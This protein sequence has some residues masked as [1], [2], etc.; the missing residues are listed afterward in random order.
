[1]FRR[2]AQKRE[3][4]S[5]RLRERFVH[6]RRVDANR[7]IRDVKCPDVIATLTE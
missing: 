4:E 1:L 7:E 2:I 5:K 3:V 6:V